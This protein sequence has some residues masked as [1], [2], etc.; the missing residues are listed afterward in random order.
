MFAT[1]IFHPMIVHFPLALLLL[2]FL[3]EVISV[4]YKK[5]ACL[6]RMGF[7][8]LL[9]GTLGAI[10]AVLTGLLFTPDFT[11]D[12]GKLK[13]THKMFG[14]IT[15]GLALVTSL[16]YIYIIRKEKVS[17]ELQRIALALYTLTAMSVAVTGFFGGNLV[18]GA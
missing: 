9:T 13:A 18:Y 8:L 15:A 12:A 2:G 16:F 3:A 1:T 5:D 14:L 6:P 11:G 7:Y 4:F 17:P 10:A